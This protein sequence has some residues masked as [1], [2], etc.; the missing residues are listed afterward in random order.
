MLK[1]NVI[2]KEY[3]VTARTPQGIEA[4]TIVQAESETAARMKADF[5]P[6]WTIV[7]VEAL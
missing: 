4:M 3:K 7:E 2:T 1:T 6:D 5:P